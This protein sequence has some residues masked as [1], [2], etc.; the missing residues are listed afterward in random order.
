MQN[1]S[2]LIMKATNNNR[3]YTRVQTEIQDKNIINSEL[4]LKY[5]DKTTFIRIPLTFKIKL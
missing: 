3:M 2:I 5:L 4:M 1:M